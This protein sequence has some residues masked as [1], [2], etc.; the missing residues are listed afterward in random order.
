L[1][2]SGLLHFVSSKS[3][4]TNPIVHLNPKIPLL[5]PSLSRVSDRRRG[6]GLTIG[7]ITYFNHLRL[8][9][10]I[11]QPPILWA[12]FSIYPAFSLGSI[13]DNSLT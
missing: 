4:L 11:L 9:I 6:I 10:S 2:H 8:I 1:S 12:P 7:F 5:T 3:F 13:L